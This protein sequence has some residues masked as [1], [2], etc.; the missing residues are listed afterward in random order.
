MRKPQH[1]QRTNSL[2]EIAPWHTPVK[3]K[4]VFADLH[5]DTGIFVQPERRAE[6]A[7][8]WR[9]W[10]QKE[11]REVIPTTYDFPKTAFNVGTANRILYSSDKWEDD[12]DFYTYFHD[13]ESHPSIYTTSHSPLAKGLR[14]NSDVIDVYEALSMERPDSQVTLP[15]L[16]M[17]MELKY[18]GPDGK[19]KSYKFKGKPPMCCAADLKTIVILAEEAPIIIQGGSMVI[20]ERGIIR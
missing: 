1:R 10:H 18:I 12:G 2:E 17:T 7:K 11:P 16:A 8:I 13:F 3:K 9:M 4:D 14:R 6:A 5:K 15:L 20:T 19:K